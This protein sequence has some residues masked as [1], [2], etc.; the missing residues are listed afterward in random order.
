MLY[1]GRFVSGIGSGMANGLYL[2][3]SEVR[4]QMLWNASLIATLIKIM[5]VIEILELKLCV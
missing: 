4:V 3:V 2:Y 5:Y 1:A